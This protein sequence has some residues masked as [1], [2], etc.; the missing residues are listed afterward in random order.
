MTDQQRQTWNIGYGLDGGGYGFENPERGTYWSNSPVFL[1]E[2]PDLD[3]ILGRDMTSGDPDLLV[4]APNSG[5]FGPY[6]F[7]EEYQD[8]EDRFKILSK[9]YMTTSDR[10]CGCHGQ[11]GDWTGAAGEPRE[12]LP[13]AK[14]I[15]WMAGRMGWDGETP[16]DAS[17]GLLWVFTGDVRDDPYPDC[18]RCQGDGYVISPGGCWALYERQ[19]DEEEDDD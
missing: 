14:V 19:W 8:G 16:L 17:Q 18:H 3:Y 7:P 1:W 9:G 6:P 13:A 10:E 15:K 4:V 2:D 11:L 5:H 12:P